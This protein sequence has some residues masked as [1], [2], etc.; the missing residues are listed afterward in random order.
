VVFHDSTRRALAAARVL[1]KIRALTAATWPGERGGAPVP[2]SL[3]AYD[4]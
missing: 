3:T 1:A 4:H 2:R